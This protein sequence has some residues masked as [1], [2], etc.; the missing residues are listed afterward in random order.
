M[1]T[2]ETADFTARVTEILDA[3]D[4]PAMRWS[5]TLDADGMPLVGRAGYTVSEGGRRYA[6]IG[7][8]GR[9]E[10]AES[11]RQGERDQLTQRA[12]AALVADGLTV[13][14]NEYGHLHAKEN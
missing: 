14:V 5:E 3:A 4:I 1:S 9:T 12:R 10:A 13:T 8:I 2:R 6:K 11:T 7:I